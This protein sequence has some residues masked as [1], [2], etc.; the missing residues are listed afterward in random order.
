MRFLCLV[1]IDKDEATKLGEAD[2]AAIDRD[3]MDYD[4]ALDRRG[5]YV[6]SMALREPETARTVRVRRGRAMVTDGP[7]VETKE[8]V[9]GFILIEAEDM[10]AALEI[11][12][13]I[14]LATIGSIEVRAEMVLTRPEPKLEKP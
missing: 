14:P 10:D 13:K 1:N 3:S 8:H 7:F 9:A 4:R 6:V 12:K 11:A 2:W 5:G